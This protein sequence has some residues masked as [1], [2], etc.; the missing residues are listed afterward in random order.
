MD[1]VGADAGGGAAATGIASVAGFVADAVVVVFVGRGGSLAGTTEG[2][3]FVAGGGVI[4]AG[5]AAGVRYSASDDGEGAVSRCGRADGSAAS[6][7]INAFTVSAFV[8][9][10]WSLPA[11]ATE[12]G[13]FDVRDSE[14][15]AR[16]SITSARTSV[17]WTTVWGN[18]A[19]ESLVPAAVS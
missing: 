2:I 18:S 17:V 15:A 19:V 12:V 16:I 4:D 6:V 10:R 8:S 13:S 11:V 14:S 3:E 1:A 7:V 9:L 5:R